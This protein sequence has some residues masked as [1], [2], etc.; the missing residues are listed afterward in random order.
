MTV[1][2]PYC[3]Q[4][5]NDST[6]AVIIPDVMELS[7]KHDPKF[8]AEVTGGQITPTHVA[9]VEQKVMSPW[10]SYALKTVLD[11]LGVA[12]LAILATTNPGLSL[13]WQKFDANGFAVAGSVHRSLTYKGGVIIPK[14][15][16]VDHGG[17]AKIECEVVPV[18]TTGNA[19]VVDSDTA[20]LPAI[21]ILPG[22][23]TIGGIKINNVALTA[24]TKLEIDFGNN[25]ETKGVD[26]EIYA[27][28]LEQKTHE[29]QIR[30]D[31]IDPT[32]FSAAKIALGGTT[33]LT[34]N[35]YV[36]LRKRSQDGSSFVPNATAEHIKFALA[37]MSAI[38][39]SLKGQAQ[40]A[41]ETS[42]LVKLAKDS[43][44]NA[45]LIVNTASTHP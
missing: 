44:G 33:V 42:L 1:Y 45:P 17:D 43:S 23:W 15:I 20:S 16:S 22:R 31:G 21:A 37:G 36:Y 12:G 5:H 19:V 24:C 13:F 34:A 40:R 32:W 26:S 25:T 38:D 41:G 39:D 30:I 18:K 27:S 9:L 28:R 7:D 2:K 6:S 14:K 29:P 35:D 11:Q 8:V 10:S 4:I 3:V